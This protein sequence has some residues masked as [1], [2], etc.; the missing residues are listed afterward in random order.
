MD[1]GHGCA[2]DPRRAGNDVGDPEGSEDDAVGG[3]ACTEITLR[4]RN[5]IKLHGYG[6]DTR[7]ISKLSRVTA[8]HSQRPHPKSHSILL[9]LRNPTII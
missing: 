3:F 5:A 6:I 9:Y 7:K 2:Q 1:N 8:A 4:N